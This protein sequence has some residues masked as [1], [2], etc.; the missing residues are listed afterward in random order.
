MPLQSLVTVL[1]AAEE[2]RDEELFLY[3][4][5]YNGKYGVI[6]QYGEV[7]VEP[8]YESVSKFS[9]GMAR[10]SA[11]KHGKYGYINTEGE[12]VIPMMYKSAYDFSEGLAAVWEGSRAGYIDKTGAYVIE[13]Q[14]DW[15]AKSSS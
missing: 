1:P 11:E 8:V 3:P 4:I 13:P 10:V 15:Y 9:E 7:I 5:K 12:L 6:N 14:F 2:K